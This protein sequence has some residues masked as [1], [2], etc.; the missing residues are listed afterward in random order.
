M[1]GDDAL[2]VVFGDLN[3]GNKIIRGNTV[4]D[5]LTQRSA[6]FVGRIPRS[7]TT[8]MPALFYQSGQGFRGIAIIDEITRTSQSD[9]KDFG[10]IPLAIYPVKITLKSFRTFPVTIDPRPLIPKLSFVSNKTYWG[11]SFRFSPRVI[12]KSD[13]NLVVA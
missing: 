7:A 3:V 4:Y 10:L 6:W 9:T 5:Y 8:G 11:H 13:Y 1:S 2:L 12:P